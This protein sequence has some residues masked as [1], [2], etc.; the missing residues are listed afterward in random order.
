MA[1]QPDFAIPRMRQL[2]RNIGHPHLAQQLSGAFGPERLR[3]SAMRTL[4]LAIIAVLAAPHSG[5]AGDGL[6][7]L[8]AAEP[9]VRWQKSGRLRVDVD[10]D[11]KKDDVYLGRSFG[12]AYVG[13]V[14]AEGGP[15]EVLSFD[16]GGNTQAS[17]CAEPVEIAPELRT[18]AGDPEVPAEAA[19][20]EGCPG[21]KAIRLS[22]GECDAIRLFWNRKA[23]RLSWWRR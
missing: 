10:C 22:G 14:R 4:V 20:V 11:G 6:A 2:G 19:R 3:H 7:R 5:L 15:P 18:D 9:T 8:S 21:C 12:K 16:I 17:L 13:L 1:R 23:R